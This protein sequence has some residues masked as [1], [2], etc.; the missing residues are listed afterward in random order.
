MPRVV[1]FLSWLTADRLL[2]EGRAW[3]L[4]GIKPSSTVQSVKAFIQASTRMPISQQRL[5]FAGRQLENPITLAEYNITHNSVLNCVIRLV[6]GKPAIYLLSPQAINKVSVSVELSREWDFAVIYPLADKSQNSKFSTSKVTWNVS[7]DS[8]G[9]LREASGREYSYLF[10]EAET[11][12]ATPMID[13]EMYNRFNAARPILTSSNSVV[14]PFHDFIGYLEMTLERLQLTVSMRTDFMTYW[15]PNF[16][17]IRDQGLDI[18]VTFVEQSMFNKAARLSI[19][20]QPS[21]VARVFMLFGAVDTTDRDENDSE[22]RNLRLDLKE[23]NDIDWAMRI[24]LDVKGLKDQRAF[25]AMEWGGMEV[26]D[27]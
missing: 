15:M 25:R 6:G 12:P 3:K 5:I 1:I 7:V 14:L 13:D 23:A 2:V 8:T 21:T 11:Q 19:T 27:V 16:L 17:H 22:W 18:A 4:G 26:Y 9:I 20:P 24:G 10:W